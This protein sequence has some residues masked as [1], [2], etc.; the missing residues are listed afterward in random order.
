MMVDLFFYDKFCGGELKIPASEFPKWERCAERELLYITG[1]KSANSDDER[2]KTCIC[3]MA[4]I[5]YAKEN[6][7]GVLSES[8]DGY[9]VSYA[10]NDIKSALYDVAKR[11]LLGTDFLYR[12]VFDEE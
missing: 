8:I 5:L 4:E 2:L 3:E 7:G 9:S 10:K 11:H 1:G 12:G 6:L